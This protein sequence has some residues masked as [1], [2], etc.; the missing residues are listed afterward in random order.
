MRA[1]LFL[2]LIVF[3]VISCDT[4]YNYIDSGTCD[5]VHDC[6]MWEY[7]QGDPYNWDSTCMMIEHAGLVD[8]FKGEGEYEEIMFFGPTSHSIRYY[9]WY[10]NIERITDISSEWCRNVILR[11]VVGQVLLRDDVPVGENNST[12]EGGKSGGIELTG[13][14]GN[15]MWLYSEHSSYQ[16]VANAGPVILHLIS[17]DGQANI[18]IAST[19]IQTTTGVVHSLHY[20]YS[21]GNL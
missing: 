15:K 16:G 18:P 14:A 4:D 19:D 12:L 3:A 8:L 17:I 10:Y 21:F 20:S 13:L 2:S 7:L 9:L 11:H 6:T 1:F 5:G